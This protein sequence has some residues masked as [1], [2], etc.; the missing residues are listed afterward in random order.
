MTTAGDRLNQAIQKYQGTAGA[1]LERVLSQV[2]QDAIVKANALQFRP[3]PQGGVLE[4]SAGTDSVWRLHRHALSQ[5][6]ETGNVPLTYVDHLGGRDSSPWQ[7]EL[8]S[9]VLTRTYQH[10]GKRHLIRAVGMNGGVR[11]AR[12]FLSDKYRRL[13]SRPLLEAFIES[14]RKQGGV[15][16]S[17]TISDVRVAVKAIIPQVFEPVSGEAIAFGIEWFNSDFGSGRYGLRVF[18]LRL[19]CV[20]GL[21][22]EDL[23]SQVHIGGRL[24]DE[25]EFSAK[26]LVA[27]T[28][29]NILASKD[30]VKGALGPGGQERVFSTIRAAAEKKIEWA[31]VR[32]RLSKAL[33]KDELRRVDE[34]FTGPDVVNLPAGDTAWRASNALS[35][36]AQTIDDPDRK[37]DFERLAGSLVAPEKKA[38]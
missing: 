7:R 26:T 11:E 30:I 38:A 18:I 3:E 28:K 17:G 20:N 4:M 12:G 21:V 2:P 23:L 31:T 37:I 36:I 27:D 25:I 19:I 16:Y 24:P 10:S 15:P 32:G 1:T 34:A 5:V 6:A 8:L 14:A 13:D 29:A 22:G 9:D 33:T 35:W